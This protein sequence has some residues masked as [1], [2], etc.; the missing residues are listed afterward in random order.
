MYP[1]SSLSDQKA[2]FLRQHAENHLRSG[3]APSSGGPLDGDALALLYDMAR[4]PA[5]S[6]DALRLLQEL[7]VYQVELDLQW[8]QLEANE[9]EMSRD[10]DHYR[11]LFALTPSVCLL[12]S[13]DGY[14]QDGNAAAASLLGVRQHELPGRRLL[15]FLRPQSQPVFEALL[16]QLQA[17]EPVEGCEL[18]VN[19]SR[20]ESATAQLCVSVSPGDDAVLLL[21][22]VG[23]PGRARDHSRQAD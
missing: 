4:D 8:A 14:V 2:R 1:D 5:R 7:Q 16:R 3:S 13:A 15:D 18:W 22:P 11:A 17:A 6:S 9:R 12:V 21:V 10:L 23:E 19:G 20:D